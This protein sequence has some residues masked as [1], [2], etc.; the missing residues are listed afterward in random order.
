MTVRRLAMSSL[1]ELSII[2]GMGLDLFLRLVDLR[3]RFV[4]VL[5]DA[6]G[7][8]RLMGLLGAD[9]D[10]LRVFVADAH[11]HADVGCRDAQIAVSEP[12][13]QVKRLA[14]R[15]LPSQPQAV[16]G[17]RL[18]HCRAHLRRRLEE[19]VGGHE[20]ADA[21]VRALEVVGVDEEPEATL[22]VGVVGEDRLRQ[23]LVPRRLPKPL[24][25]AER[26]RMLRPALDVRDA[27]VAQ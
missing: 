11:A 18:L 13:H 10:R 6:V 12:S 5:A 19:A 14:R 25:F 1:S 26:H 20:A 7:D 24:D 27:F 2:L 4:G 22:E 3:L 17:D 15:L 9:V 8:L 16:V 23:K 21:L